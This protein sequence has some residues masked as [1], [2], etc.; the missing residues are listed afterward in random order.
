MQTVKTQGYK[1]GICTLFIIVFLTKMIISVAPAFLYLNNNKTVKAAI[2]QLEQE[3]KN[4]KE[5]PDKDTAKEKKFCDEN[6]VH[7][8]IQQHVLHIIETITLLNQEH[9]LYQ[10]VYHPTVLTPPP[11]TV[12]V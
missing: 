6:F 10:Q 3:T 7:V 8:H 1:I 11:N 12:L 9:S 2:M 4:D 5:D